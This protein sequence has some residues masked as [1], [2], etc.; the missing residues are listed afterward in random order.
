MKGIAYEK[1]KF[2]C[3][4]K[5]CQLFMIYIGLNTLNIA[6]LTKLIKFSSQLFYSD[7]F[8]VHTFI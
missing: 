4:K 6:I 5:F 1:D 7:H 3:N 8:Y 2:S